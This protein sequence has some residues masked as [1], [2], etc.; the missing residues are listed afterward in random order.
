[1]HVADL[2][3]YQDKTTRRTTHPTVAGDEIRRA[4]APHSGRPA[5]RQ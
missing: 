4:P 5:A 2:A 1:M 3:M